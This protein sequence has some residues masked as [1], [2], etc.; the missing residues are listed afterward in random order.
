MRFNATLKPMTVALKSSIVII[1]LAICTFKSSAQTTVLTDDPSYTGLLGIQGGDAAVTFAVQNTNSTA[2]ILTGIDM[3]WDN[4]FTA[5]GT[6]NVTLWVSTT[7]LGG[8]PTIAGPDWTQIGTATVTGVGAG[9]GI[10]PT[11]TGLAYSLDP[12]TQYRFAIESSDGIAYSPAAA[13]PNI[14]TGDGVNL[15]TSNF[16]LQGGNVGYAGAFPTPPNNPRAFT[17]SIT[18]QSNNPPCSGAPVPGATVSTVPNVCPATNFGLALQTPLQLTGLSYQWQ[19]SADGITFSDIAG[20]TN[21]TLTTQ[22]NADT[23]YQLQVSC[24]GGAPVASTPILV[25]L[26]PS[27]QCYCIPPISD[28][29]DGDVITNVTLAALNN[30]S[31][32]STDGYANYTNDLTITIPDIYQGIPNPI[33]VTA[34]GGIYDEVVAA[35]VDYD[36]SGTFDASEYSP[37]GGTTGGTIN[38]NLNVSPTAVLGNTRMR[39]RVQFLGDFAATDACSPAFLDFGETEDYT[40]NIIPCVQGIF[41]LQPVNTS[42]QCG[43]SVT[44][45]AGATGTFLTYQ[46]QQQAGASAPWTN[47]VD[48]NI[49]SG[50]TTNTLSISNVDNGWDGYRYRLLIS[51]GCT[52][53]DFSDIVTLTIVPLV[54]D[55]APASYTTCSPIPAGSP[56][57]LSITNAVGTPPIFTSGPLNTT[58][59]DNDPTGI[60]STISVPPPPAGAVI[61]DMKVKLNIAHTWVGDLSINLKAPNNN[62]LNL[63]YF[64]TA[65]GGPGTAS[66]GF[67]NT[68]ITSV[69]T[70]TDLLGDGTDPYTGIFTPD[71]VVV[72]P[73]GAPPTGALAIGDA[74]V[75]TFA[76]LYSVPDGNWTIGIYDGFAQD[77]GSLIDWTLTFTYSI[78]PSIPVT[79]VWTPAA[80]LFTD[81]A[82]T[83]PYVAG[84][85]M[86]TVYAAPGASTT[87]TVTVTNSVCPSAPVE[88]PVKILSPDPSLKI[89]VAPY[90]NIYPGLRTQLTAVVDPTASTNTFQWYHNGDTIPGA[91][92]STYEVNFANTGL[93]SYTVDLI[94]STICSGKL[95]AGP[96]V[97]GD[98][99]SNNLFIWPNPSSGQFQVRYNDGGLTDIRSG[100]PFIGVYDSKGSRIFTQSFPQTAPYQRMDVDL[101]GQPKGTYMV[102]L[103]TNDGKLIKTGRVIIR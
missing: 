56:V 57:Q 78:A 41:D 62:I 80:G 35:W 49:Y 33:S 39:V 69:S 51:G 26:T 103:Y 68:Q 81:A 24:S 34:G 96:V 45:T 16:Q 95:S 91:N 37:I 84:T 100:A 40:V 65:T 30:S 64:L 6:A 15:Q 3:S 79:G 70:V 8:A 28:C 90:S 17:G 97:I 86:T 22:L 101:S 85:E 20:A 29:T 10:I 2:R 55:I 47:I 1:L 99:A 102:A 38:A 12:S 88:V 76:D 83:T 43:S 25:T 53:I 54:I 27:N 59:P 98:S 50:A 23:Y 7:S 72:P 18:F 4:F 93:G 11:F 58:I 36:H 82:G 61:T 63:D 19:S 89:T 14:F 77:E 32:C 73:A 75:G 31:T 46:W 74:N 44:F 21:S 92:S 13:T 87:Y 48:N 67:T 66:T 52:A 42:V 60:I 94:D 5:S 71:A 9:T